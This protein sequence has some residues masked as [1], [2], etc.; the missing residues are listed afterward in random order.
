MVDR[1]WLRLMGCCFEFEL[2]GSGTTMYRCYHVGQRILIVK[3]SFVALMDVFESLLAA[4][5]FLALVILISG[6][7]FSQVPGPLWHLPFLGETLE[8]MDSPVKV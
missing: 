8:F 7:S 1:N 6:L 2:C 4:F 3:T 5:G